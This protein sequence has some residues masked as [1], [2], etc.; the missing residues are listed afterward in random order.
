[1]WFGLAGLGLRARLRWRVRLGQPQ[2]S[3][4]GTCPTASTERKMARGHRQASSGLNSETPFRIS[5]D[6]LDVMMRGLVGSWR[7][8]S[9]ESFACGCCCCCLVVGRVSRA[10]GIV[11]CRHSKLW[12]LL[13]MPTLLYA[14]CSCFGVEANQARQ[15]LR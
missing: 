13:A 10:N 11:A 2:L 14:V 1:M 4:G 15:P 12:Q 5:D 6:P 3:E 8:P 9:V 7:A